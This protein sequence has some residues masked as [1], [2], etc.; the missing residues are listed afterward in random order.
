MGGCPDAA[1]AP[2]WFNG[3]PGVGFNPVLLKSA[4]GKSRSYTG[5][6]AVAVS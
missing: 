5:A 1:G 6:K 2:F 4:F 3:Q